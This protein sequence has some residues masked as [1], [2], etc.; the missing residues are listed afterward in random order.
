[1]RSEGLSSVAL[2]LIFEKRLN[3]T[4]SGHLKMGEK[5]T[6]SMSPY[7]PAWRA[8]M[9]SSELECLERNILTAGASWDSL[10]IITTN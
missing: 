9:M 10:R 8:C 1:M 6:D 2:S 5:S 7:H 3:K 4:R